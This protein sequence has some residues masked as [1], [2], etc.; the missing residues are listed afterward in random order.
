MFSKIIR[1]LLYILLIIQVSCTKSGT[2]PTEPPIQ[3]SKKNITSFTFHKIDNP[4][5]ISDVTGIIS[6]DSVIVN[7]PYATPLNNLIPT[8]NIEGT[9]I[10]PANKTAQ[11]FT[12]PIQ[13]VVT[14]ENNSTKTYRVFVTVEQN[15]ATLFINSANGQPARVGQVYALDPIT[16]MLK[17]KYTPPSSSFISSLDFENG[18]LY[19]GISNRITAIDTITKNIKWEYTTGG[20]LYSTPRDKWNCLYELF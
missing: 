7:L 3:S 13:F 17:W 16:G 4:F 10:S 11:N 6:Q 1:S 15:S 2:E 18:I 5:L 9:T 8:I 19:T 12:N 20:S 14:A